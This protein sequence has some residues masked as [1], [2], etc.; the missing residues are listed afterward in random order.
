LLFAIHA[1]ALLLL[2][3]LHAYKRRQCGFI[4]TRLA[5]GN[6]HH[7]RYV[8]VSL[9]TLPDPIGPIEAV[10]RTAESEIYRRR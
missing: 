8:I 9:S 2:L 1:N 7:Q 10:A 5:K 3:A 4:E 6:A